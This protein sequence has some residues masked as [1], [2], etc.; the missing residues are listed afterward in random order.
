MDPPPRPS[1]DAPDDDEL[2]PNDNEGLRALSVYEEG[3]S[4][5]FAYYSE[6][7]STKISLRSSLFLVPSTHRSFF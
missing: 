2:A 3:E 6:E 5:S 7:V 1:H 4:I